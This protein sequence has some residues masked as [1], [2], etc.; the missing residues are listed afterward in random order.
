MNE[1]VMRELSQLI[2]AHLPVEDYGVV[3]VTSVDIS[4][5]LKTGT[6]FISSVGAHPLAN[7][8][9]DA[10]QKIRGTLQHELSR[11]I[12]MK[13]TPQLVFKADHGLE[14]GQHILDLLAELDQEASK[15]PNS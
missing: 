14:R 2:R 1:Q 13:Y 12:V 5:D 3:T 8:V 10:L 4:K 11:K 7:H 9:L 6:V 15:H